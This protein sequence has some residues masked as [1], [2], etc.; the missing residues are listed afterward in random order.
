MA[1]EETSEE[2]EERHARE[3]KLR[4]RILGII[5]L[6]PAPEEDHNWAVLTRRFPF[7]ILGLVVLCLIALGGFAHFFYYSSKPEFC[8][9]CHYI[10]PNVESWKVSA[11]K[12]VTC[13][14]CH[15]EP[16]F[17]NYVK[18]KVEAISELVKTVTNSQGAKPHSIVK[19]VTC[20]QP[21]CHP[22]IMNEGEKTFGENDQYRFSHKSHLSE[23]VRERELVCTSCHSVVGHGKPKNAK[24]TKSTCYTC[25][26]RGRIKERSMNPIS[27]CTECHDMP[28][29]PIE[30]EG[31]GSFDHTTFDDRGVNCY[32][33]HYDSVQGRSNVP[34]QSCTGCHADEV[35][36]EDYDRTEY[37]H[38]EHVT[39]ANVECNLCHGELR[40][41]L[42]PEREKDMMSCTQCHS[43]DH[44]T[45]RNLYAGKGGKGVE[46]EENFHSAM[47]VDCIACHRFASPEHKNPERAMI[48]HGAGKKSCGF[49]HGQAAQMQLRF[50]KQQ[51]E[52]TAK[53]TGAAV[54]KAEEAFMNNK[55]KLSDADKVRKLIEKARYNYDMVQSA[56]GVHNPDYAFSLMDQALEWAE[57]AQDMIDEQTA[58]SGDSGESGDS[59]GS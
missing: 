41:G 35:K 2:A 21:E 4:W 12:D 32:M 39:K 58:Q 5:G 14:E 45:V 16:G 23:A 11:H 6:K 15:F 49:C 55:Q 56:N 36:L 40:H 26:F 43:S 3:K 33:C 13:I 28:K 37:I 9:T 25:H 7:I 38:D 31:H 42:K 52:N 18:G 27:G 53:E 54:E 51:L 10:K 47:Q 46:G 20:T 22:D 19:D 24:V 34:K 44:F 1:D 57:N 59:D 29:E 50:W 48:N 8:A 30:V 17:K